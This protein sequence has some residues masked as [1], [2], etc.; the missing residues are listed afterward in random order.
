MTETRDDTDVVDLL[1]TDHHDVLS[2]LQEIRISTDP[3]RRRELADV[4]IGELVRH[5]VAEEMFVYPAMRRHLPGG[6]EAVEHDVAEHKELERLMKRWEGVEPSD[7]DFDVVL[8]EL[9]PV[10]RDHVQDEESEQFPEL[11]AHIPRQE[12]V[13]LAGQVEAAKRAAPTRPHPLAPNNALFHFLVGP[14]VGLVDRLRD[15]WT[16]RPN[17]S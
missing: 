14:G 3:G 16:G 9:E 5:S 13:H 8:D 1:T 12:L 2:M 6:D 15:S 11:R 10:L 7:A 4:V 17:Q